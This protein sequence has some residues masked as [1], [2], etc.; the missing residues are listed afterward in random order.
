M[1]QTGDGPNRRSTY[2]TPRWVKVFGI[3]TLIV[4]LVIVVVLATGLGGPHGPRRHAPSGDAGGDILVWSVT[5]SPRPSDGDLGVSAPPTE[6]G[7]Q[8]L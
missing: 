2:R 5:A 1:S 6:H 3:I 8:P 4:V 7:A